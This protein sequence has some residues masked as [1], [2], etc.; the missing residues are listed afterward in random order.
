GVSVQGVGV[1]VTDSSQDENDASKYLF[2][3]SAVKVEA[4]K[5]KKRTKVQLMLQFQGG[6]SLILPLQAKFYK[7]EDT[8]HLTWGNPLHQIDYDCLIKSS[9]TYLDIVKETFR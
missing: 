5:K 1:S 6:L 4:N 9:T 2:S 3:W 8:Q 7:M